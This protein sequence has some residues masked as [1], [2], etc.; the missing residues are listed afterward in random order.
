MKISIIT[1]NYNNREGLERTLASV[2]A[3]DTR[4]FEYLVVDGGSSDGSLD[5]ILA[6]QDLITGFV[7]EKDGGIYNAMNKGVAMAT[8]DYCLFLNSGDVLHSPDVISRVLG[9]GSEADIIFGQVVNVMP[10]GKRRLYVPEE[11]MTLLLIIQ[12][13]IH[14]AGSFIKTALMRKYPYDE[15]FRV[16]AD[17]RFFVQAL[18]IDNCSYHNLDFPVCD[19]EIGGVSTTQRATAN[20]ENRRIM[21]ELFPPRVVLDYRRTNLRIQRMTEKLVGCRH[22]I[23]GLVCGLDLLLIRFFRL[24]LGRRISRSMSLAGAL[25]LG[26]VMAAQAQPKVQTAIYEKEEFTCLSTDGNW[27]VGNLDSGG[28]SLV[29]RDLAGGRKWTYSYTEE[30][31]LAKDRS[32]SDTGV[33]VA[34]IKGVPQYW[35]KGQWTPLEVFDSEKSSVVGSIT[36]DGSVIV[37]GIGRSGGQFTYPV[38]WER[39]PEGGYGAPQVLPYPSKDF[40]GQS[41]QYFNLICISED[42]NTIGAS[43]TTGNGMRHP[44]YAY[45]KDADDNW[46][47]KMLGIDVLNP[48]GMEIPE[49]PG[50]YRGP[51]MPNYEPYLSAEEYAAFDAAFSD[52]WD[53]QYNKGYT[54]DEIMVNERIFVVEF[55]SGANKEAYQA[56][57]DKFLASYLPWHENYR[58]YV[59]FE[60]NLN[61][62]GGDFPLNDIRISLD[63]KYIYSTKQGG[64]GGSGLIRFDV[65]T[66]EQTL[67]GSGNIITGIT[68]DYSV[69]T[70]TNSTFYTPAYIFAQGEKPLLNI[71]D[72]LMEQGHIGVCQWMVQNMTHAAYASASDEDVADILGMGTPLSNRDMSLLCFSVDTEYWVWEEESEYKYVTFVINV[73]ETD[74]T[75]GVKP[76]EAV[77]E[78]TL[79]SLG[80]GE[81]ECTGLSTL[82]L[83][84]L[85]G[86]CVYTSSVSDGIT[87]LT[88][89]PSGL[90][91]ARALTPSGTPL[92]LKLHL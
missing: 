11:T 55:M 22:K 28:F 76:D 59:E 74:I 69:L 15:S 62:S 80:H 47:Y 92:T 91:I 3:Q 48:G 31:I 13:G 66:G 53:D 9:C 8:G 84:T 18:V 29:I 79:R 72:Y 6:N 83:Y 64:Q 1:I 39:L 81:I 17:R 52:W 42:G 71:A 26:A 88:V 35:E 46:S 20:A 41:S 58:K 85:D 82:S 60:I 75:L 51:A 12:T 87:R 38:I 24:L 14:H 77:A 4:N 50:D 45:T 16:C 19:F 7:S 61:K 43:Q 73:P 67:L 49:Y 34:K 63:G 40:F 36:P 89:L 86:R 78:A 54:E 32:I 90:Y 65:E 5:L 2:R 23:V 30:A 25:M 27:A 44:I 37:G 70:R 21:D 56:I 33:V 68:D 57:L 10:G